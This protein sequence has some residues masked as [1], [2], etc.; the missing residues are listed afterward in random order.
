MVTSTR[1]PSDS[2]S[3]RARSR[4]AR[5]LLWGALLEDLLEVDLECLEEA[6]VQ[7]VCAFL[8]LKR[9]EAPGCHPCLL[10]CHRVDLGQD[11]HPRLQVGPALKCLQLDPA[12]ALNL[13]HLFPPL[14]ATGQVNH[15]WVSLSFLSSLF[16]APFSIPPPSKDPSMYIVQEATK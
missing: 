1:T 6:L 15:L 13:Q 9:L 12:L 4:L 2:V 11:C 8:S 5:L 14:E 16:L 10:L 3:R 7:A